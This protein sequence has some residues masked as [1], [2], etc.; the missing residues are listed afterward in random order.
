MIWRPNRG[1][2][3]AVQCSAVQGE[4]EQHARTIEC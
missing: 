1:Q 4:V 2:E 3:E